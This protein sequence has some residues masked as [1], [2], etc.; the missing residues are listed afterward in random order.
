M[1]MVLQVLD[2][3]VWYTLNRS[4]EASALAE[5][6]SADGCERGRGRAASLLAAR[7]RVRSGCESKPD[8]EI[9]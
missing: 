6:L 3:A 9:L 7:L 5:L 4:H 1:L 8:T 2:G